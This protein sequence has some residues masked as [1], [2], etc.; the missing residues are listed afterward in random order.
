MARQDAWSGLTTCGQLAAQAGGISRQTWSDS[1][2]DPGSI[3]S[4]MRISLP[5]EEGCAHHG[6]GCKR[7]AAKIGQHRRG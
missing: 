3:H 1:I 5:N 6:L 2:P 4:T 7:C